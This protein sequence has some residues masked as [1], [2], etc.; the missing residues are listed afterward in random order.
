MGPVLLHVVTE[1]GRGYL[2]AESASDKMHGVVQYDTVTGKQVKAKSQVWALHGPMDW[3]KKT[4]PLELHGY[5]ACLADCP[6]KLT[7][8]CAHGCRPS[9]SPTTLPTRLLLRPR[10][11]RALWASTQQWA[12]AP[13]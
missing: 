5:R 4:G 3:L 8:M 10:R 7:Q 2:P 1:K 13:A 9:L 12:V 11:I 6:G